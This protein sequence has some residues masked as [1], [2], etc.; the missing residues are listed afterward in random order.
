M[1]NDNVPVSHTEIPKERKEELMRKLAKGVVDRR[2]AVP[3]IMFLESIKPM[4][5][6]ASQVMVFFEPVI[7]SLFTVANYRE[8]SLVLE[9]RDAV[10]N[11]IKF[12][13]EYENENKPKK[14]SKNKAT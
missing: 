14:N 5:F 4:N 9:E 10:E 12:I 1:F 8:I 2:M 11:I 6:L 3:A 13:E 7:L